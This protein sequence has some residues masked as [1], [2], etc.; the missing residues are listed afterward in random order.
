ME[1]FARED[2]KGRRPRRQSDVTIGDPMTRPQ[3][4]LRCPIILL[5]D[6]LKTRCI[7]SVPRCDRTHRATRPKS[8][9]REG[10]N[11][12]QASLDLPQSKV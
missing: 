1:S 9:F 6:T 2:R 8:Q 12:E 7:E 11:L 4:A 5:S 10:N 3:I